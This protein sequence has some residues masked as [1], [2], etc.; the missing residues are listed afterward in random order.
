MVVIALQRLE[1]PGPI[2]DSLAHGRPRIALAILLLYRVLA[3][4]VPDAIL[5]QEVVSTRVRLLIMLR[6]VSRIPIEHYVGRSNR[7]KHLSGFRAR[8]GIASRLGFQY[9]DHVFFRR[10]L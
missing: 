8:R 4:A 9:P 1:L 2:D 10:F 3:V 7:S 5:R 6:C